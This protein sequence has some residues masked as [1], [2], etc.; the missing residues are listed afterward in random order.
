MSE[1]L[2]QISEAFSEQNWFALGVSAIFFLFFLIERVKR[3]SL[4]VRDRNTSFY[5][6]S[7]NTSEL[8]ED[9]RSLVTEKVNWDIFYQMTGVAGDPLIRS[10][11]KEIIDHSDGAFSIAAFKRIEDYLE[12]E[13]GGIQIKLG[14]WHCFK[15]WFDKVWIWLLWAS[16]GIA[17]FEVWY[18]W[19]ENTLN[20]KLVSLA[21]A[22]IAFIFLAITFRSKVNYEIAREVSAV[23]EKIRKEKLEVGSEKPELGSFA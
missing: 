2:T 18:L 3:F 1:V 21:L 20:S 8:D 13:K 7:L 11:V 16:I 4:D 19:S 22:I 14:G 6:E 10:E 23:L 15:Y 9:V 5:R 17:L 12:V